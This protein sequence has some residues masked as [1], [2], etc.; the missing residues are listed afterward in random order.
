MVGERQ[1]PSE[2]VSGAVSNLYGRPR[3][4]LG[5]AAGL[6]RLCHGMQREGRLARGFR[7]VNLTTARGYKGK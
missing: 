3:P 6:L 2:T 5:V 1:R 7:P 4:T